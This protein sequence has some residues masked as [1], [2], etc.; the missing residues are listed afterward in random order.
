MPWLSSSSSS[1][2]LVTR[3]NN[4]S[5]VMPEHHEPPST[6][7]MRLTLLQKFVQYIY[8]EIVIPILRHDFYITE[9]ESSFNK[10][11]YYRRSVWNQIQ[12]IAIEKL[13]RQKLLRSDN[14][15]YMNVDV[16]NTNG[17]LH[18]GSSRKKENPEVILRFVPK[19][20][21][22]RPIMNMSRKR[23]KSKNNVGSSSSSTSRGSITNSI[24]NVWIVRNIWKLM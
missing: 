23:K 10:V 12:S 1:P 3:D 14:S 15:T 16:E 5:R 11:G 21:T 20:R 2:S 9:M 13:K 24:G 17:M 7:E 6:N 4:N 18:T 8:I 19:K 22:V